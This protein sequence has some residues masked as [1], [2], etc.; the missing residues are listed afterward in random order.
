MRV[1]A[2]IP[3]RGGSKRLPGKNIKLLAGVPLIG[4]TI[5]TAQAS[6]CFVD[7]LVSTD[8]QHIADVARQY[9]ANVPWLRPS[10]L[11]TDTAS[12]I[13]VVLHAIDA[14]ENAHGSADAVMLLQPTSPFRSV[15]S[16]KRAVKLFDST[17][18]CRPV[19]SVCQAASHP[20]W[21]FRTTPF[22]IEPYLGWDRVHVRSQDLEPAW[23]LNGA[24][25]LSSVNRL[26]Q[27]R[28][29]L[30]PDTQALVI[31][32]FNESIDVDTFEDFAKCEAALTNGHFRPHQ[33]TE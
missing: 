19:V 5:Q 16:I 25:Y 31:D 33:S 12:S 26:R 8:D 29:F 2:L 18:G 4:W 23:T 9:G 28:S 11:A 13:D 10:E 6:A 21:C 14:W 32:N 27:E 15:E 1:I 3:A 20:A 17:R 7:V 24:I 22:G 30:A